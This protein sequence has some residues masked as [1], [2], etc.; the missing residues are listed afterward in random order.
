MIESGTKTT[1]KTSNEAKI[2]V[3][4]KT[5]RIETKKIENDM[6]QIVNGISLKYE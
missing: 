5:P 2:S 1:P 6:L 4:K 3:R